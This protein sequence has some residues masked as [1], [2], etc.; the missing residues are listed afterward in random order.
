VLGG[1]RLVVAWYVYTPT[2]EQLWLIGA[3][4]IDAQ[5][6]SV[7]MVRPA[8][9]RFIPN[10]DPARIVSPVVGTLRFV[11]IDCN[12]ARVEYAFDAPF[13]AGT[14]PVTRVTSVRGASCP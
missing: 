5:A 6:A 10:F 3:G 13:G 2:R 11:A 4:A 14:I 1:D 7:T 9:G 8:G 12:T